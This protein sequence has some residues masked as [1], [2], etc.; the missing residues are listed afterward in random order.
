MK[1]EKLYCGI[2]VSNETIDV[3]IQL[4][5]EQFHSETLPNSKAG[6]SKLMKLSGKHYH[7]VMEATG[8]YHLPLSF[9]LHTLHC[10]Y[11]VV[12]A[13]KI[14]R[15]I[16][17]Q[18][19]RNK[20]DKKDAKHIC[21]YGID[22]HPEVYQMPDGLYF[23]CKSLNNAI[24]HITRDITSYKNLLHALEKLPIGN[25]VV[26]RSYKIMIK[27]LASTLAQLEAELYKKLNE[28]Q[29]ELVKLV[30]SVVGIGKRATSLLIVS[31]QGFKNTESYKQLISYA[32]LSPREYSSGTSINGRRRICKNGGGQLRHTL[33]MCALNA[34][35][36]NPACITLFNRLV[37][38]GKNKK[39]AVIAVC[40]KLLKQ[41]FGVV[42]SG[43]LYDRNY[44]QNCA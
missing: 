31:T 24:E 20:S 33:Y 6:F 25:K 41:V 9:Y 26:I 1:E 36:T 15:Y 2:D 30:S 39:L 22:Q 19:E 17:M 40:N 5:N 37:E 18:L 27:K 4:S 13:I 32:G 42:K 34:K 7:F 16:Q 10:D 23:E 29:P 28:W 3:C 38:K 8:I 21:R 11:S 35:K 14:K 12:N 43:Q 44:L